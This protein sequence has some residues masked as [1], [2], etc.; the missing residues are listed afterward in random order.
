MQT[1]KKAEI[2]RIKQEKARELALE[3]I[4]QMHLEKEQPVKDDYFVWER[5]QPPR[6]R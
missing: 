6:R 3:K 4:K 1:L 2:K 5:K